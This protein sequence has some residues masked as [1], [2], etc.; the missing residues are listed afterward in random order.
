MPTGDFYDILGVEPSSDAEEIKKAYRRKVRKYHP[1]MNKH[2]G[3]VGKFYLIQQAYD[4]L[5]NPDKRQAYNR[6]HHPELER[7]AAD[8][9]RESGPTRA[10][11]VP[12]SSRTQRVH[13]QTA[14]SA[15]LEN[16]LFGAV[17][18]ANIIAAAFLVWQVVMTADFIQR[19]SR[20]AADRSAGSATFEPA[21]P[22]TPDTTDTPAAPDS[23]NT[24][25][26]PAA[27]A[28]KSSE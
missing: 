19:E 16:W 8:K 23:P 20:M 27:P 24:P 18:A 28:P 22:D 26:T 14:G 10:Q 3:A 17:F 1:D 12:Y 6:L 2:D 13:Y 5:A 15:K 11:D 25:S 4:T 7:E 21:A 9:P